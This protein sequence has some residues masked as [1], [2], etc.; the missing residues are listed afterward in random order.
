MLCS[1]IRLG[2]EAREQATSGTKP[3]AK[4]LPNTGL[5]SELMSWGIPL[6]FNTGWAEVKHLEANQ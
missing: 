2:M 6:S 1:S 5:Q 4:L 3:G